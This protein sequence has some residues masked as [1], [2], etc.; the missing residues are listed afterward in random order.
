MKTL[1]KFFLV[2]AFLAFA[3]NTFAQKPLKLAYIDMQELITSMPERDSA[4]AKLQKV[5]KQ[6]QD[7]MEL[8]NVERN[9]K[10]E[11][12][13][14]NNKNWTDLV[15]QSREQEIQAMNQK[16]EAFRESAMDNM[17]QEEA[18]LMQPILEKANKAIETVA[19]EQGITYVLNIQAV[20][21]KS[22]DAQDILSSVK[23]QLGI[24]K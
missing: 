2:V 24:K 5:Q 3:N 16:I 20:H 8:L 10:Y 21:Y 9:K 13:L 12:Y 1:F 19:K 23:Q 18:K 11:D 22:P 7:E 17:Q 15:R 4:M 14:A 6:L